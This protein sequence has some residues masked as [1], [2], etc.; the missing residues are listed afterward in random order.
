MTALLAQGVRFAAV[1]GLATALHLAVAM[2]LVELGGLGILTANLMAFG[3]AVLTSY[4]GNHRWTFGARGGHNRHL[5]GFAAIAVAGL[6]VNQAIVFGT[7]SGLDLDYRL[8]LGVAVLVVPALSFLGNRFWSFAPR[9]FAAPEAPAL[10]RV[11][12]AE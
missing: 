12:G 7:V 5:P 1:G 11:E 3:A 4:L 8:A 10:P 6:A 2:A 9:R